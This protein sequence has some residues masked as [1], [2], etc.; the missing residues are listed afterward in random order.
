MQKM[1]IPLIVFE[2]LKIKKSYNL[3]GGQQFGLLLDN[4]IFHRL[5]V[6][7]NHVANYEASFK[8]QQVILPLLNAKYF[9]F[10]SNLSHLPNYLD[11]KKNTIFQNLGLPNFSIYGKISSKNEGNSQRRS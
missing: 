11:K 1:N 5:A 3:I 6:S 8:A 2:I 7:Q 10:E 4:Q 9:T